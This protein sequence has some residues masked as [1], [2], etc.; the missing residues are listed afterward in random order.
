MVIVVQKG[1]RPRRPDNAE[2]LGFSDTLW[3][4]TQMCWSES[5]SARPAAQRLLR[6]LQD[7]SHT[8]VPPL[9]Y[10]IRNS[11]DEGAGLDFTSLLRASVLV[12]SVLSVLLLPL[13]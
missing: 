7:A 11:F 4:L 3:R 2:S 10:P 1:G 9:E 12:V 13:I 6:C 5:P 8:W